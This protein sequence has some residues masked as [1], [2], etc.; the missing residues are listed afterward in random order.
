MTGREGGQGGQ[1][2]QGG[3]AAN[4]SSFHFFG[5]ERFGCNQGRGVGCWMLDVGNRRVQPAARAGGFL[6]IL[7]LREFRLTRPIAARHLSR[8]AIFGD[9]IPSG[10]G[11][12]IGDWGRLLLHAEG[13]DVMCTSVY[14]TARPISIGSVRKMS[15]H[16]SAG[17]GGWPPVA[18]GGYRGRAAA[19]GVELNGSVINLLRL[20]RPG[21]AKT[22]NR[23]T[24]QVGVDAR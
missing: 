21:R 18:V 4:L 24:R 2:G 13:H 19:A 3:H 15:L 17:I 14:I 1:G 10:G 8:I 6:P 7:V 11:C 20:R 16:L 12:A 5:F 9:I 23:A 22:P